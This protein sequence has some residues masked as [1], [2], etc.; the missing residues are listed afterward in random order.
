MLNR[1]GID[2]RFDAIAIKK[3]FRSVILLVLI[4]RVPMEIY[5]LLYG[6][7]GKERLLTRPPLNQHIFS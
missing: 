1:C 6:F 2:W 4:Y 3:A 7:Y 5:R